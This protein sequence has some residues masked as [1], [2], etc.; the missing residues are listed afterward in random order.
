MAGRVTVAGGT[1]S[2]PRRLKLLFERS[3][4][5]FFFAMT[6]APFI[7]DSDIPANDT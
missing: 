2:L 7:V 3:E 5:V 6:E 1:N 4:P